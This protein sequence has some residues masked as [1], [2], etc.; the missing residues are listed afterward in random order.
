MDLSSPVTGGAQAGLTS[1]TY[2]VE[3]DT[4]PSLFSKQ[5]YVSALG[6]TQVGVSAHSVQ[7]PFT[8]AFFR[9]NVLKQA[10]AA[11]LSA[12]GLVSVPT[13]TYKMIVR[14]GVNVNSVGGKAV[15]LLRLEYEI[16]ANSP[17]ID[18]VELAAMFSLAFGSILQINGDV[19]SQVLN[20]SV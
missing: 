6:G 4:P 11:A 3:V 14:K 19:Q 13:N 1:P 9:P 2:T 8:L 20:G 7:S 12:I 5:W 10:T 18:M 17:D 15:A 16:P